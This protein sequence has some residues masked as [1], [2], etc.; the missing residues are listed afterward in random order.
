MAIDW[1]KSEVKLYKKVCT[2]IKKFAKEFPDEVV[3]IFHFSCQY[4]MGEIHLGFD[5][6]S[7]N[8]DCAISNME[9]TNKLLNK[10]LKSSSKWL[11]LK[12]VMVRRPILPF[13]LNTFSFLYHLY[14][15]IYFPDWKKVAQS[16]Y[17]SDPDVDVDLE[18][19]DE[20]DIDDA[21]DDEPDVVT[22][23]EEYLIAGI[24]V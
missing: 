21:V 20:D 11:K 12:E 19:L 10:E 3:C 5:T 18:D 9:Y 2:A 24:R 15:N 23:E 7:N 22:K 14:D 6:P 17:K 8:R 16:Q 1:A 13:K 4:Q